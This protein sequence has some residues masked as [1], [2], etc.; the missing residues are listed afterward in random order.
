VDDLRNLLIVVISYSALT[1]CSQPFSG[2]FLIDSKD[3]GLQAEFKWQ[4]TCLTCP[5]LWFNT[6]HCKKEK[7]EKRKRKSEE[8]ESGCL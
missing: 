5:R 7:R 6:Q 8:I 4:S 3:M 2:F 1:G